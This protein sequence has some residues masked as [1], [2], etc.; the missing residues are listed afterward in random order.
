MGCC[1]DDCERMMQPYMDGVL[2]EEQ[3]REAQ[4]HLADCPECEKRYRFE[5]ELRRFVRVAVDEPMTPALK[6]RLAGL[7]SEPERP[8]LGA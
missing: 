8:P 5:V 1:C 4:E 3:I 2:S 6:A 7:R